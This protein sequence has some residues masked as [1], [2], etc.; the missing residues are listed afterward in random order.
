MIESKRPLLVIN[1]SLWLEMVIAEYAFLRTRQNW[2]IFIPFFQ[3]CYESETVLKIV[4]MI[5]TQ[6]VLICVNV[7]LVSAVSLQSLPYFYVCVL[8]HGWKHCSNSNRLKSRFVKAI[9]LCFNLN[10]KFNIQM[11]L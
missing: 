5:E 1:I 6:E 11:Y 2:E 4:F 9:L 10:S 7:D 3:F 8:L